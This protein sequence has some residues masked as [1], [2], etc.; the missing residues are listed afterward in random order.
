MEADAPAWFLDA[1]SSTPEHRDVTVDGCRVHYR[2][3]G[4]P[5]MPGLVLIHGGAAHSGWWDHVAPL[6]AAQYRVLAPDL[7]GHG[8]SGRRTAYDLSHWAE[9]IVTVAADAAL[10]GPPIVVGHSM[11]GW[12]S[13]VAAGEHPDAIAGLVIVDSPVVESTTPEEDAARRGVAFGPLRVYRTVDGA[14]RRFRTVPEQDDSLPYVISHIALDSLR[15]VDGGWA[16]KF[17][18]Q[19][20]RRFSPDPGV[21]SQVRCR[22]ALFRAEHGLV[23]PEVGSQMY[24][25]LGRIAPVV[26]IPLAGHHVM[27]D[28]PLSLVTGLRTLLADWEHS[29]PLRTRAASAP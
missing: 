19:V 29:A 6:L 8:D 21:L 16:W 4:D 27:L 28:Q 18:P 7:S 24:E 2:A 13:I 23:T 15:S 22:V 5:G 9:E 25:R 26:E 14:L 1:V 3:W 12:V 17:D 10:P 20:F 11:G